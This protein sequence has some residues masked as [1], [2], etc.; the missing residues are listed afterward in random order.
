MKKNVILLLL[1][2]GYTFSQT[3]GIISD[4]VFIPPDYFTFAPRVDV[5]E[6]YTDPVFGTKIKRIT[7]SRR[8]NRTMLG[9]YFAN[10]EICY[11]NKDGSCFF[12][13]AD[14]Q[15]NGK[16]ESLP[17]LY[18]GLTGEKIKQLD[19]DDSMRNWNIRW[20]LTGRYKKNGKYKTFDPVYHFY[21]FDG[22]EIRLYDVRTMNFTVIRRFSEY[23][24]I[25]PGGGEG[26]I[27]DDGRYWL[28]D[29]EDKELF[30]YDLVDDIKYPAS[31]F[32]LGSLGSFGSKIGVDYAA[33]SPRGNYIIVSWTTEP[34]LGSQFHGIEIYDK[35]WNYIRQV[36]PGLI[37][38]E[39]G[40]NAFGHEVMYTVASFGYDYYWA[41][42]GVEEGD[43]VSIR[44]SDGHIRLLKKIPNWAHFCISS[45]NTITNNKYIYVSYDNQKDDPFRKWSQFWS[46]ILEVPT[47]GSGIVRRLAH[48]RTRRVPGRGHKYSQADINVNRQ[49]TRIFYRSTYGSEI[50]DVYLIDVG[51][52]HAPGDHDP[53]DTP[54][55][56]DA[57]SITETSQTI[58]WDAPAPAPDGDEASYF[59]IYRNGEL[60]R[61]TQNLTVM[62]DNLL[63]G[64]SLFIR[65]LFH[66]RC[67]QC[68]FWSAGG[69]VFN[70]AAA[71]RVLR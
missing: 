58:T 15:V 31:D 49:G 16:L 53:P 17:F 27:S 11:F 45:N 60:I 14:E 48:H 1:C 33:I 37:H 30:V 39:L 42:W 43:L 69:R 29:G 47:D 62:N 7:N 41:P 21:K 55:N 36:Y 56:L 52:R 63:M 44:L 19:G 67:G 35:E 65:N 28:L 46:E 26:D 4:E 32:D 8:F 25:G 6:S 10:S 5:G 9:G 71:A 3:N 2:A 12:A 38:W 18:D 50:G 64:A 51:T 40:T 59:R 13:M 70:A 66:G 57:N 61:V 24:Y 34:L 68:K 22:N 20:A 54:K 23:S